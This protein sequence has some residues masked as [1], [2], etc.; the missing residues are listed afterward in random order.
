[1]LEKNRAKYIKLGFFIIVGL[2]FFIVAIFYVGSKSN[3]FTSTIRIKTT[4][5]SVS[6]LLE[7]NSVRFAGINVGTIQNIEITATNKV[8]V[9]MLIQ[10]DVKKFIKK[11]S[12][13]SIGSEGLVGN[14]IATISPGTPEGQSIED[15]DE[16]KSVQPVEISDIFNSL[17]ESTK[18]AQKI[19]ADLAD[20]VAK[21]NDGKGTLGQ[22]VNNDQLYRTVDSTITGF[23]IATGQVNIVIKKVA[24]SIDTISGDITQLTSKIRNITT[25]IADITNKMNSSQ[26][27]VGTLLTD[28]AFARNL[29]EVIVN[30]NMT[31]KNLE[32]GSF[33]FAQ[34][35]EALKHNFLFKGYFED[36]GYW[37]KSDWEKN[38]TDKQLLLKIRE[39]ELNDRERNLDKLQEQLDELKKEL[40][41]K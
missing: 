12:E 27:I 11:D 10:S 39:Q 2:I 3:L 36:I 6:G 35:M 4:F 1:M 33:G 7:G 14:K 28:T 31:T 37:D 16:L 32:N 15:G 13:V 26:S 22:L 20:I 24:S 29:K 30:A 8:V 41:N 40:E 34:N 23:A 25:D 18:N 9:T 17:N 19:S 5:S 38:V 21:V